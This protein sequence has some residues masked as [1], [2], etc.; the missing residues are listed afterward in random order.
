MIININF[1]SLLPIQ[2]VLIGFI[3]LHE[4]TFWFKRQLLK[5]TS[6]GIA[7]SALL[8]IYSWD[9]WPKISPA[10]L[11]GIFKEIGN[12]LSRKAFFNLSTIGLIGMIYYFILER[13]KQFLQLRLDGEKMK[14]ISLSFILL[15]LVGLF[16]ESALFKSFGLL[17]IICFLSLIPLEFIFQSI[18]RLRSRRNLIYAIYILICLLDSHFEVRLKIFSKLFS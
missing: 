10:T 3:S 6:L 1:I 12:L 8:V 15:M 16:I 4:K 9:E 5:Y 14:E 11:A 7:L 18:S 13:K 2:L 17:W